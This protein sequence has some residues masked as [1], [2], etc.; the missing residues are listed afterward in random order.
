MSNATQFQLETNGTSATL[1]ISEELPL[2]HLE[3]LAQACA[4]LPPHVRALRIDLH[5]IRQLGPEMMASLR[6]LMREWRGTRGGECRL[7]FSTE[8]LVIT[9]TERDSV[10]VPAVAGAPWVSASASEA[11]TAA[12]L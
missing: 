4:A 6:V 7:A 12:Y 11:R 9:Y 5:G 2:D 1:Y 10:V 8:N 3:A